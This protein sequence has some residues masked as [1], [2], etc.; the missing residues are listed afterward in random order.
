MDHLVAPHLRY[1]DRLEED[2]SCV[3]ADRDVT[4]DEPELCVAVRKIAEA[5]DQDALERIDPR[6]VDSSSL[7]SRPAYSVSV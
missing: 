1:A 2:F 6:R 7:C 5:A 3:C 4:V